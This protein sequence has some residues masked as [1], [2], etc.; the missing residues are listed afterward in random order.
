[1][2]RQSFQLRGE[3]LQ[4]H[5]TLHNNDD[6]DDWPPESPRAN[7]QRITVRLD[8]DVLAFFRGKGKGYQTRMNA[9]L[10]AYVEAQAKS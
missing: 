4:P 8:R 9:A 5:P 7:K 1:M 6:N 3:L 2:S 10:R